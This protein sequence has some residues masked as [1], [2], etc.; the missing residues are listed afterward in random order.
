MPLKI[1][2]ATP[3]PFREINKS[4]DLQPHDHDIPAAWRPS[5]LARHWGMSKQTVYRLIQA[6]ELQAITIG[7]AKRITEASARQFWTRNIN[8]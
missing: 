7:G 1:R 5:A 6:G 2:S 3:L 4:L 8:R